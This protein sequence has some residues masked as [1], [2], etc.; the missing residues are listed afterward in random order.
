MMQALNQLSESYV[1]K[2]RYGGVG[3]DQSDS[4]E[5]DNR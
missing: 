4:E 1:Q 5:E 3:K 2:M